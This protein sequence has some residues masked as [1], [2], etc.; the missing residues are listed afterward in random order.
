MTDTPTIIGYATRINQDNQ[1]PDVVEI[2]E[3]DK[4]NGL[5]YSAPYGP[6]GDGRYEEEDI[7]YFLDEWAIP[8]GGV[9]V[10]DI[11]HTYKEPSIDWNLITDNCLRVCEDFPIDEQH[12]EN[13]RVFV[14]IA[15]ELGGSGTWNRVSNVAQIIKNAEHKHTL[16]WDKHWMSGWQDV[17]VDYNGHHFYVD[18]WTRNGRSLAQHQ[19]MIEDGMNIGLKMLITECG[20]EADEAPYSSNSVNL[21]SDQIQK[22]YDI[23]VGCL[24]WQNVWT[25]NDADYQAK[26]LRMPVGKPIWLDEQIPLPDLSNYYTKAESDARYLELSLMIQTNRDKILSLDEK[27]TSL[28]EANIDANEVSRELIKAL[29]DKLS[30]WTE[31]Y[32]G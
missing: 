28:S 11:N 15:N 21:F 18:V 9:I 31:S 24:V 20:A 8:K 7:R 27:I 16:V 6:G 32:A 14:E 13:K 10:V 17:H 30:N 29:K 19:A 3:R 4:C 1:L 25:K 22:Y 5:R 2:L 23:G 26:G 12:P